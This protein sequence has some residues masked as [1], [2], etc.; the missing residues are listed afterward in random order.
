VQL[1]ARSPVD[2]DFN[3]N[4]PTG[5]ILPEGPNKLTVTFSPKDQRKYTQA[6]MTVSITVIPGPKPVVRKPFPLTVTGHEFK[7]VGTPYPQAIFTL[8][9]KN[10]TGALLKVKSRTLAMFYSGS[11]AQTETFERESWET[12]SKRTPQDGEINLDPDPNVFISVRLPQQAA[13]QLAS[14]T[15]HAA[16]FIDIRDSADKKSLVQ[17]CGFANGD[18][19]IVRCATHNLP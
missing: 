9:F 13:A 16:F 17:L 1:N 5:T 18:H 11:L 19:E 2:G 14:G 4:P 6:A 15:M 8:Y 3:Y 10:N 7:I 12:M